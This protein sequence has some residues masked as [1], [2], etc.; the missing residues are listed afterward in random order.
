MTEAEARL[1]T[2]GAAY[3]G[4][5]CGM[6][7]AEI[8]DPADPGASAWRVDARDAWYTARDLW[9][10]DHEHHWVSETTMCDPRPVSTCTRCGQ[11]SEYDQ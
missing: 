4:S 1:I 10:P 2:A 7:S 6:T 3:L 8:A 11:R 9:L 5:T